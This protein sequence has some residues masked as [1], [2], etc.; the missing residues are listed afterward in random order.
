MKKSGTVVF[1]L[2]VGLCLILVLS[3]NLRAEASADG[4]FGRKQQITANDLVGKIYFLPEDTEQLP[5]FTKLKAVGTIYADRIDI[6]ERHFEEGFPG[7]TDR[8]EWFG[9]QYSGK[10]GIKESG[11]YIFY[12]NSDD[13]SKL[14]IDGKLVID[15]DGI[16]SPTEVEQS[17]MLSAGVHTLRVEYFQGPRYDIALQLFVAPPSGEKVIFSIDKFP[18]K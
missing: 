12:L 6:T 5:D 7:V 18:V 14:Y 4:V 11:E 15:N 3:T 1:G 17:I 13:G 2:L 16:H 10:F 8:I 9:V